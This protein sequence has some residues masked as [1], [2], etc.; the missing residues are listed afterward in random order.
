MRILKDSN[1]N[2]AKKVF[3]EVYV[4]HCSSFDPK[5]VTLESKESFADIQDST[6]WKFLFGN[7]GLVANINNFSNWFFRLSEFMVNQNDPQTLRHKVNIVDLLVSKDM[8]SNIPVGV[9]LKPQGGWT[10]SRLISLDELYSNKKEYLGIVFPGHTRVVGSVFLNQPLKN[11]MIYI[12]KE[13]NIQ[14]KESDNLT[15]ILNTDQL[16]THYSPH[17]EDTRD[18]YEFDFINFKGELD[19]GFRLHPITETIIFKL[20]S[21]KKI[22]TKEEYNPHDGPHPSNSYVTDTYRTFDRFCEALFTKQVKIYIKTGYS[23]KLKDK[24]RSNFNKLKKKFLVHFNDHGNTIDRNSTKNFK[25]GHKQVHP[26]KFQN[27]P[28]KYRVFYSYLWEHLYKQET[29]LH[30]KEPVLIANDE[31]TGGAK[32]I[33]A[34]KVTLKEWVKANNNEGIIILID[35]N[36]IQDIERIYFELLYLFSADTTIVQTASKEI[37]VVN[38]AHSHWVTTNKP[39]I[40]TIN[41]SFLTL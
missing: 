33:E 25:T 28:H 20:N 15:R 19:N 10:D 14:L 21:V 11:V 2:T 16:L 6:R 24:L 4:Y 35:A 40:K 7:Y 1:K 23:T 18:D 27:L 36:I 5:F 32:I 30:S 38:C 39:V 12:K 26:S 37:Q 41:K 3:E 13:H 9:S 31:A 22:N 17:N 34:D 29:R 8:K